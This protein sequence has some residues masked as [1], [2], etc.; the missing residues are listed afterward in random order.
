M[1]LGFFLKTIPGCMNKN[2]RLLVFDWDG[3]RADAEAMIVDAMQSAI[4]QLQ[5][6]TRNNVQIRPAEPVTSAVLISRI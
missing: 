4:R 3:T 6:H 1:N 2:I 5:F